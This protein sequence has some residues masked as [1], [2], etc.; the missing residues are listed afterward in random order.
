MKKKWL[1]PDIARLKGV[2]PEAVYHA[3]KVG[4]I[5]AVKID[6]QYFLEDSQA[7]LYLQMKRGWNKSPFWKR[8]NSHG[9][10]EEQRKA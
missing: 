4:K 5:T 8:R 3:I 2:T 9:R 1:V 7:Q 10:S 6:H